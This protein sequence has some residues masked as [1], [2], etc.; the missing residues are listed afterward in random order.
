MG[1]FQTKEGRMHEKHPGIFRITNNMPVIWK[2]IIIKVSIY[3]LASTEL[4]YFCAN[5]KST[6][7]E[8][9]YLAYCDHS[10][11]TYCL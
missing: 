6:Q 11:N 3:L 5:T 7:M 4:R 8:V 10:T 1:S 9:C 2:K